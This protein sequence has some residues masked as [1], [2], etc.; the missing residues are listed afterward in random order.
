[1]HRRIYIRIHP[2]NYH[3]YTEINLQISL[4]PVQAIVV[5][6]HGLEITAAN[7]FEPCRTAFSCSG[8]NTKSP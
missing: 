8:D 3:I 6:G 2:I 7:P 5:D 1:M 4:D